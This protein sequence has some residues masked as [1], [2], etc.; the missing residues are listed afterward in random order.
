MKSNEL[1]RTDGARATEV[2]SE[3]IISKGVTE[4]LE[5]AG[6]LTTIIE[7]LEALVF[8]VD[9]TN[10]KSSIFTIHNVSGTGTSTKLVGEAVFTATKDTASSVNV[11]YDATA[12]A[13]Q[14]QN[15]TGG[16]ADIT[17]KAYA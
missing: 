8:V 17:V 5:D 14:I 2:Q 9:S 12:G 1:V 3:M 7:E 6:V 13:V 10:T 16:D 4:T 11:Y 15:L